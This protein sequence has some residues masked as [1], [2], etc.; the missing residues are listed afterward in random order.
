M[1]SKR[2]EGENIAF[3]CGISSFYQK[4][5]SKDEPTKVVKQEAKTDYTGIHL[6]NLSS[7]TKNNTFKP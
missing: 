4:L 2:R 6:C 7:Q 3:E 1:L 5:F